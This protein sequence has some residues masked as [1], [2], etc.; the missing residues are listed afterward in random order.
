MTGPVVR[1]VVLIVAA[2]VLSGHA[3]CTAE[4]F[5]NSEFID[6][7]GGSKDIATLP[8]VA[9]VA[10]LAVQNQTA[11]WAE[12]Q[13]SYR[14]GQNEVEVFTA[15]VEP[16]QRTA[17]AIACPIEE[18]T[19][20]DLS[21]SS[22]SGVTMRLGNGGAGDPIV[23]VEPFGVIMKEGANYDCGDGI[24]FAVT[25][26]QETVSGYRVYAYVQRAD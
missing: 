25:Y 8:G 14:T 10:L 18:M 26:S 16:G 6:A 21:D 2:S 20:G 17:Q 23:V 1:A 3:G 13:V 9:P 19:V 11:E 7:I 12:I 22:L 5:L 4:T 15:T 24:T